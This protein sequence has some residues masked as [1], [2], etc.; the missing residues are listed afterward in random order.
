MEDR[1]ELERQI[2]EHERELAEAALRQEEADEAERQRV[3]NLQVTLEKKRED[4]IKAH[5][6][7]E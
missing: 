5:R 6:R 4:L 1:L 7:V 2:E 3:A